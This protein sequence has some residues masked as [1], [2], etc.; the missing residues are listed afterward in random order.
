MQLTSIIYST[1]PENNQHP[2]TMTRY[3]F[4]FDDDDVL[5]LSLV[6]NSSTDIVT[7]RDAYLPYIQQQCSYHTEPMS[8]SDITHPPISHKWER[9]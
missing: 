8:N 4:D 5:E 2:A 6:N 7:E 3:A 9:L 1:G